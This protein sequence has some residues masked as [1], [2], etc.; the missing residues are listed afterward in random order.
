MNPPANSPAWLTADQA[1]GLVAFGRPLFDAELAAA[2]DPPP[3]HPW[4]SSDWGALLDALQSRAAGKIWRPTD[5]EP[6]F[7]AWRIRARARRVMRATGLDAGRL[8]EDLAAD[9]AR[10]DEAQRRVADAVT[11]L[12]EAAREGGKLRVEGRRGSRH[13]REMAE[14]HEPIEPRAFLRTHITITGDGWVTVDPAAPIGEWLHR[15]EAGAVDWGELRLKTEDVAALVPRPAMVA[16]AEPPRARAE[17]L[18]PF[19]TPMQAVAWIVLRDLDVVQRAGDLTTATAGHLA[20]RILPDGRRELVEVPGR[21]GVTL[22]RLEL[23]RSA[24]ADLATPTVNDARTQLLAALREGQLTATA[25]R[26][27]AP[28]DGVRADEWMGLVFDTPAHEDRIL[29]ACWANASR[30]AIQGPWRD[31]LFA[32]E[33]VM[34]LWPT[35]SAGA[36]PPVIYRTGAPGR[37]T[38]THIIKQEAERRIAQGEVLPTLKGEADYLSEWLSSSHKEAAPMTGKV[39]RDKIR[40]LHGAFRAKSRN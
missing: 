25:S 21:G 30:A 16:A 20:E 11:R 8:A 2:V 9:I 4:G 5:W 7:G 19:L 10:R 35:L 3:T 37:P 27:G 12:V 39:I 6:A 23:E 24:R 13:S 17:A 33:A 32:R 29:V 36:S 26:D 34:A 15:R 40:A 22:L 14:L 31:V 28:R 38:S 18:P 1:I